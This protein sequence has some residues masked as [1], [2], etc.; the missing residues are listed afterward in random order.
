[1]NG[2]HAAYA[3][4]LTLH[5]YAVTTNHF[6]L[7]KS[8]RITV[9]TIFCLSPCGY[10]VYNGGWWCKSKSLFARWTNPDLTIRR[11]G[12]LPAAT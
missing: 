8:D 6:Y 1:M 5:P 9:P 12:S 10:I 4:P 2:I 7:G 11:R 3:M